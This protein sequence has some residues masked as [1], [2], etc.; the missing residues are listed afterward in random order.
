[1]FGDEVGGAML[2]WRRRG[3][4]RKNWQDPQKLARFLVGSTRSLGEVQFC[5][6]KSSQNQFSQNQISQ[7]STRGQSVTD[8]EV[9]W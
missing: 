9:T 3:K 8:H 6:G 7:D 5:N 4:I 2:L 1:M